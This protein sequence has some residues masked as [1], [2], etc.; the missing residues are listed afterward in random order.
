MRQRKNVSMADVAAHA[1]VSPQTVSR[2][3]NNMP[4]V[5]ATTR[6]KVLASMA[7]L[8]YRPNSAAR[9]LKR[10]SFRSIAMVMSD[11]KN[12][13]NLGTL[14]GVGAAVS[15]RDYSLIV[16]TLGHMTP[17]TIRG[18]VDALNEVAVDGAVLLLESD[19]MHDLE[20]AALPFQRIAVIDSHSAAQFP[21]VDSDQAGGARSAIDHLLALGHRTVHHIAG[22]SA[23]YSARRRSEAWRARLVERGREVPAV[24][25]GDWSAPSGYQAGHQIADAGEATAVFVAND[26]MALGVMRA[27][28]ERG[29]RV[30]QDVSIVGFDDIGMAT[31]FPTP[32]TTVHQEFDLVGATC[33]DLLIAQIENNIVPEAGLTL[34]P[35]RLVIR[36]STA[37]P[38][39][40]ATP[41]G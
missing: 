4:G 11:V 8:K 32:L 23:S 24:I 16:R 29:I 41:A 27:F 21:C 25:Q 30:P 36:S 38:R 26:E 7:A 22:P 39:P 20:L 12:S 6:D 10:G 9:A 33:V 37:A 18:A 15:A 13:G 17:E 5:Q 35:T 40:G 3:A 34:V 2:V 1:G 19:I 31:D 14:A 28:L